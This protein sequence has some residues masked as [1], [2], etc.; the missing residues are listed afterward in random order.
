M[1]SCCE[2]KKDEHGH[3][4]PRKD[5][6]LRGSLTI[7][8]L[9]LVV[10]FAHIELPYVSVFGH[11]VFSLLSVMWWGIAAGIVAVGLMQ[12]VPREYFNAMLGRGDTFGGII[13]AA[14]AGLVLDLCSHGIL[15]VGA[16]LY[17]RGA[18]L[19]QVMTFLIASPWNSISLTFILIA[20][21]GWQW[22]L[23]FIGASAVIAIVTGMIYIVLIKRGILPD[24]PHKTDLP[25]D[26]DIKAD[27]K[28]RLKGFKFNG[29]FVGG[30]L[31]DGFVEGKMVMRWLFFGLI[32]AAL[33]RTFVSTEMLTAYFGPTLIGLLLTLLATTIIEVCSEGSTPVGAE[34]VTRAGAPGNGFTFLMAGV[35]TDYTE[36]LVLREVTKS[37]KIALSLPLLTVPQIVL[38]G[39]IMNNV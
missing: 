6:L 26:F 29:K 35:S 19:A 15:M 9:A 3:A 24:N 2:V 31:R 36:M 4:H 12:R 38:L 11:A 37:W 8:A 32:L 10:H 16:K 25:V 33:I 22:T 18:S 1:S 7:I 28:E 17:E 27:A 20:L 14:I 23:V 13:R 5:W 21:V 30:V 34:L 39:Y